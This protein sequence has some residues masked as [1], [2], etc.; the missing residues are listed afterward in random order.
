MQSAGH[1]GDLDRHDEDGADRTTM[2]DIRGLITG[3]GYKDAYVVGHHRGGSIGWL[4]AIQSPEMVKKLVV[5]NSPHPFLE[6]P[7]AVSG[8]G[9]VVEG[10][11]RIVR[12]ALYADG[13]T[14][15]RSLAENVSRSGFELRRSRRSGAH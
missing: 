6:Q 7:S 2:A 10:L 3:L 13:H 9:P 11:L 12:S 1:K 4:L 5:F 15:P 8:S 14:R